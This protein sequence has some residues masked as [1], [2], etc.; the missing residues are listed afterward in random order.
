MDERVNRK[1]TLRTTATNQ[2][3]IGFLADKIRAAPLGAALS[4]RAF[5]AFFYAVEDSR[6]T[7]FVDGAQSGHGETKGNKA[8]FFRKVKAFFLEVRNETAIGDAGNFQ[9]DTL[10]LLGDTT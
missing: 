4:L 7:L 3:E 10:F 8:A 9:A 6:E 2:G 5:S 1:N